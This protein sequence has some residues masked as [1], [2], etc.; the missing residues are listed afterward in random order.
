MDKKGKL[1]RRKTFGN[2]GRKLQLTLTLTKWVN[3]LICLRNDEAT[4]VLSC[5]NT[6]KLLAENNIYNLQHKKEPLEQHQKRA[7]DK[8]LHEVEA[9]D[10]L[11]DK[12][13]NDLP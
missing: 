5:L 12:I 8:L 13:L 1:E 9:I 6:V 7:L 2:E 11:H 10:E 3:Q 4:L